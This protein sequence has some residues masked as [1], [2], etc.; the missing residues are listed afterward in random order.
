MKVQIVFFSIILFIFIL[1]LLSVESSTKIKIVPSFLENSNEIGDLYIKLDSDSSVHSSSSNSKNKEDSSSSSSI[2]NGSKNDNSKD[3]PTTSSD[4]IS[5]ATPIPTDGLLSASTYVTFTGGK[6]LC[7]NITFCPKGY[8]YSSDYA[9]NYDIIDNDPATHRGD[10]NDGV[11]MFE[12]PLPKNTTIDQ[13]E[14]ISFSISGAVGCQVTSGDTTLEFY[15]Q[16]LLVLTNTTSRYDICTCG[17]CYVTIDTDVYKY[18]ML[19]YNLTGE[20]KFQIQV[21]VNSMCA[22][23][24]GIT[25]YYKPPHITPTPTITPTTTLTP[26][27][28]PTITPTTTPTSTPTTTPS[29]PTPT[30]T[31]SPY[32]GALSPQVKKYIIIASSITGGLLISIFSFVFIRK[33]LNSKRS[34][35]T[36]IKDGKD[37][38][39][40]QIK[41]GVRIGKGNF[42]E[43]YL[44]TWRGSEVAVKKL[45]AHN[46]NENIL[47]EFNREINLMK[48]LRHP[49]VIQFLGSCLIPPD[50][51]ICTEYMPRGSLYSILHN[52]KIKISWSLVKRMMIDAAKGVIYLHGSTPVILHRDLKSHNLLVDENWKVKVADFG[53]STIEQQ[54]ATMTACGTP[55]WTSPEVLRSQRYTEKADVYSFGIILWECATRQDP[56]FGIPPFQVIFAVGRE[57]MRPPTPKYGPLKYIQ[58]LKDCLNENPSQRPT[59]EQCLEI[60]ESIET[61]GFDDIPVNNNNNSNNNNSNSNN[62]DNTINDIDNISNGVIN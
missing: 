35:Y 25:L 13:V 60:L 3:E 27:L 34:G 21:S 47:K 54:G 16:D 26:T 22:T 38:D 48:N 12:D 19:G 56:Y 9:C 61:K 17:S 52:D 31:K 15:I 10:W 53:L 39:T 28:T 2:N 55:C 44:G 8:M 58:L 33:R 6:V 43:V 32:S 50:I 24:V 30:P 29:T 45:P 62:N 23:S 36:Q 37:I 41:I 5:P 4:S 59:M 49:N 57:G 14:G 18:N 42:G 51:C 20:N 1:F 7:E 40:Q 11:K 46:I